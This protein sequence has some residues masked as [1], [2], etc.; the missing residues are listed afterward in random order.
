MTDP[1]N[2]PFLLAAGELVQQ[3]GNAEKATLCTGKTFWKLHG[4]ER[5]GLP[6]LWITD[7]PH[8]LRKQQGDSDHIGLNDSVPAI[9]FPPAVG[10]A[11]TWNR[12]LLQEIGVALGEA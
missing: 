5:L 6:S 2:R 1:N 12:D 8:G 10:L 3:L 7:G 9:C 11:S 4:V